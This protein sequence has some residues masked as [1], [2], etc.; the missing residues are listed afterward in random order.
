M[1][2]LAESV[3]L[4]TRNTKKQVELERILDSRGLSITVKT[5]ADFPQYLD[6]VVE[7][8]P[9]F[10]GN[11]LLKARALHQ[12][13]GCAAIADDSG[14]CVDALNGMPGVLSAR[15]SGRHGDDM[16]NLRLV[17]DQM[18]D[19]PPQRRQAQFVAV[20]AYVG[21]DGAEATA[22]G[23]MH[24]TLVDHPRGTHGFGY[25]PIFVADGHDRTNAELSPAQKDAIS[26]RSRALSHLLTL[27]EH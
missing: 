26:H 22:R 15:W 3:V 23:E 18:A 12:A 14:L 20:V 11:A 1:A 6:E 2:R 8:A 24:G 17:L 9:D 5:L 25:D 21:A 4:A 13:L 19:V 10:E 16:A 27:L 7:D